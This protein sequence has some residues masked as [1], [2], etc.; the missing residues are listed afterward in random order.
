M[1]YWV[2]GAALR[3]QDAAL[4]VDWWPDGL[5][6]CCTSCCTGRCCT[7]YW[8]SV[9]MGHQGSQRSQGLQCQHRTH[10]YLWTGDGGLGSKHQALVTGALPCELWMQFYLSEAWAPFCLTAQRLWALMALWSSAAV[11]PSG[12]SLQHWALG[13]ALQALSGGVAVRSSS[14]LTSRA[15]ARV[16][17]TG[18]HR[19]C[20]ALLR[21]E[22]Y[23]RGAVHSACGC[24]SVAVAQCSSTAH[25]KGR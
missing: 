9:A 4:P 21:P 1:G 7:V 2:S 19:Q 15:S 20:K 24:G 22:S 23:R 3:A 18:M 10:F 11:V 13:S 25:C 6:P 14:R 12:W 8:W 16:D 17:R 5:R